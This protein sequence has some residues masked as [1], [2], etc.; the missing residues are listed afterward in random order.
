[1]Y[2]EGRFYGWMAEQAVERVLCRSGFG[3]QS[4]GYDVALGSRHGFVAEGA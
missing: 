4:G 1:M 2:S 3:L